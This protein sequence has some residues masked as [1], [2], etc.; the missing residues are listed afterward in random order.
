[1][2]DNLAEEGG[3][4]TAFAGHELLVSGGLRAVV[5]GAKAAGEAGRAGPVLVFEDRT[6]TQ[7]DFDLQGSEAEVLRKLASHPLALQAAARAVADGAA[8]EPARRAGPGRPKLGVVGREV[9]LLP[10]HWEWLEAQPGGASV[11]LR[12]LVEH[13]R[14]QGGAN[15]DRARVAWEAAAK[16]M[17]VMAGD[18]P[19]FEEASRALYARDVDALF[20]RSVSWPKDI[21]DHLRRLV[22]EATRLSAANEPV[23]G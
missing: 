18:L 22:I 11:T 23:P 19:D 4:Y 1:M 3:T 21:A 10:R 12:R 6:G 13:A 9:T 17:W 15:A 2:H 8:A 14:K 16:F 7:I 5:L 20:A